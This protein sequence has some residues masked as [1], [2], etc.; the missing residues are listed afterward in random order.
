VTRPAPCYDR[1]VV[2][3]RWPWLLGLVSCSSAP[4]FSEAPWS[5]EDWVVVVVSD[6]ARRPLAPD[7]QLLLPGQALNL[8]LQGDQAVQVEAWSFPAEDAGGPRLERCG[9]TFGGQGRRLSEPSGSWSST[10]G[11][12]DETAGISLNPASPEGLLRLDLREACLLTACEGL[13]VERISAPFGDRKLEQL[14]VLDDER[15]IVS[16]D[17]NDDAGGFDVWSVEGE[18]W[19]RLEGGSALTTPPAD[20]AFDPE[21]GRVVGS[22][23]DGQTFEIDPNTGLIQLTETST[24]GLV[25]SV[26]GGGRWV[27]YGAAG[28]EVRRGPNLPRLDDNVLSITMP[29]LNRIALS[30][31]T[32]TYFY[33]GGTGFRRER[34]TKRN[35]KWNVAAGDDEI[36]AFAGSGS[37][38]LIRDPSNELWTTLARPLGS[39]LQVR[40]LVAIGGQRLLVAGEIGLLAILDPKLGSDGACLVDPPPVTADLLNLALSPTGRVA[41]AVTNELDSVSG[42]APQ[43]LRITVP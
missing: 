34:P 1:A 30:S 2:S 39:G 15:V 7:P 8:E 22:L 21:R 42:D 5:R 12:P 31:S 28:L 32:A 10:L 6:E 37:E 18:A 40:G 36:L 35:E 41:Y 29:G 24:P 3:L 9:P 38:I 14:A 33:D 25:R 4:I 26:F 19:R 20:L 17:L 13:R 11:P 23:K 43:L 27:R 16:S